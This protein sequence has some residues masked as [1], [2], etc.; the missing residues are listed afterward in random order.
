M[1][2]RQRK[3][4]LTAAA[5]TLLAALLTLLALMAGRLGIDPRDLAAASVPET[6]ADEE[7]FVDPELMELGEE[8]AT[9]SDRA[10]PAPLGLPEKADEENPVPVTRGDN[11]EPAPPV[12]R[13]VTSRRQSEVK[14]PEPPATE[15]KP[16]KAT[17]SMAGKFGKGDGSPDGRSNA[18]GAGSTGIGVSG[19]TRGRTFLGCPKP[20]VELRRKTVVVVDITVDAAGRV[21][22]ASAR[23]NADASI[24]RRC[25]R[26]AR[27]AR[28]S[29]KKG[30][31]DT[32]GT[33]TFTITPRL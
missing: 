15:R 29:E 10:A 24:R 13:P 19:S 16:S 30:A 26:A 22:A 17:A 32:R 8:E 20:D 6:G 1:T 25:E 2:P 9:M 18:A 3:D 7:L 23:G 12:E 14:M 21:T 33:I 4:S 27:A 28:W 31:A 11:P 5:A